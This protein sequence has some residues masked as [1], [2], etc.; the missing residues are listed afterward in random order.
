M[1]DASPRSVWRFCRVDRSEVSGLFTRVGKATANGLVP[2]GAMRTVFS[3]C[4]VSA[5]RGRKNHI[6]STRRCP[7]HLETQIMRVLLLSR[8]RFVSTLSL[9]SNSPSNS[10]TRVSQ[11]PQMPSWQL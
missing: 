4:V 2:G 8:S 1:R 5:G 9:C 10:M 3:F 6:S 11:V 7:E